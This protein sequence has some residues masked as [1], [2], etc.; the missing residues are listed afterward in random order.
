[1]NI[2]D[3]L[4]RDYAPAWKPEVGGKLIGVVTA[5]DIRDGDYGEYE[6]LTVRQDDGEELAWHATGSVASAKVEEQN[7]QPGDKVGIK[8][9]GLTPNKAGT[10]EYHHYALV[11]ERG[12]DGAAPGAPDVPVDDAPAGG[13]KP[14]GDSDMPFAPSVY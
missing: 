8:Y 2:N 7:P 13:S 3:L 5:R 9:R 10:N 4:D 1:M 12:D 6:I 11:V 14:K